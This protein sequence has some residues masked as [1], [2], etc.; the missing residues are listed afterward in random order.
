M[1][2]SSY[3]SETEQSYRFPAENHNQATQSD[4]NL[5][6]QTNSSNE[7]LA[8]NNINLPPTVFQSECT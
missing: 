6:I 7:W 5:V 2:I 3:S 8:G 1:E 4:S